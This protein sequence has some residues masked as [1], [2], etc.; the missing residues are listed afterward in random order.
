M[1]DQVVQKC[2]CPPTEMSKQGPFSMKVS[3]S[4][5]EPVKAIQSPR[6]TTPNLSAPTQFEP[7]LRLWSQP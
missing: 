1:R 3:A 6:K 7:V 4:T 5:E 2:C